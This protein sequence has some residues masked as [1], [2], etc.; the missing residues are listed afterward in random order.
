MR[1]EM[2]KQAKEQPVKYMQYEKC[3]TIMQKEKNC[4]GILPTKQPAWTLCEN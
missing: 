2:Q 3:V 1:P 4:N